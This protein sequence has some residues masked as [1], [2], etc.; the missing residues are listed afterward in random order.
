[1]LRTNKHTQNNVLYVK[2]RG[3][4]LWTNDNEIIRNYKNCLG[5]G[6]AC[7]TPVGGH[8]ESAKEDLD[9]EVQFTLS[10][11]E[12]AQATFI[13]TSVFFTAENILHSISHVFMYS[14][15]KEL[16]TFNNNVHSVFFPL[17]SPPQSLQFPANLW[18]ESNKEET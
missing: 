12:T 18:T 15:F 2:I 5:L 13:Y 8:V 3:R 4:K 11:M 10:G 7:S 14:L 16:F 9:Q 6:W 1:M 17:P